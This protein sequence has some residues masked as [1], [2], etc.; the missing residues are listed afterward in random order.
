MNRRELIALLGGTAAW[1]LAAGAQQSKVPVIGI[2]DSIGPGT[3]G[4][5]T[6]A[7]FRSGLGET[8]YVEGRNV[9]IELRSTNQYDL[10][11]ALATEL[12]HDQVAVI[13]AA[14][15][16]SAPAAKAA[17]ATIPIV[18]GIG[19][20]PF[21][22]GLVSNLNR[23]GGNITGATFFAA[24]LLQKQVGLL[25]ELAPKAAVIG[26]LI[27]PDNPRAE[28]D[29]NNVRAAARTLGLDTHVVNASSEGDLDPAFESLLR[30]Q[31]GALLVGGDPF[32]VRAGATLAALTARHSIPAIYSSREHAEA[33]G[34]MTYGANRL[35]AYRQ[36]GVYAGRI[37]KG[38]KPGDLPVMQ[39]T[40]FE[41]VIN[42]EA[43]KALHLEIPATLLALAD[44]VIE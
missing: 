38:E 21:E 20:D 1:P 17:T 31:A 22:L 5:H 15:G 42:L 35:D 44:E 7:A 2:L 8:G 9:E 23:P 36:A 34:L 37:L 30:Q 11:P 26:F 19:G 10:L 6:L 29:A 18:F 40:K 43:A 27:N 4:A 32:I 14:G 28:T 41:L 25:H 24:Q 16:P 39:P 33:G 3:V 13:A 12:V